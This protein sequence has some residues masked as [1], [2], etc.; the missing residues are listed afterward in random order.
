[1]TEMPCSIESKSLNNYGYPITHDFDI[2][3]SLMKSI[4]LSTI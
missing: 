3:L 4:I 1:M 2:N